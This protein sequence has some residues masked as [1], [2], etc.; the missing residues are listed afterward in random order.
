MRSLRVSALT[1]TCL[2]CVV[3]T[4]SSAVTQFAPDYTPPGF[5]GRTGEITFA[6]D[7]LYSVNVTLWHPSN[8]KRFAT[9]KIAGQETPRLFYDGRPIVVGDDWGVQLGNSKVR[10]L[11]QFAVWDKD[12]GTF[13]TSI[14][15]FHGK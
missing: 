11:S 10:P 15:L 14:G 5:E 4:A 9:W 1:L 3:L 2:I 12:N 7:S 13:K 6:N 8:G